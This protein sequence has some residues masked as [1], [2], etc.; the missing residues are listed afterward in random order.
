MLL[1]GDASVARN[2]D[3]HDTASSLNTLRKRGNI[4]EKEILLQIE[5]I[6][7]LL[8]NIG[9]D[10]GSVVRC[11]FVARSMVSFGTLS[12]RCFAQQL[13]LTEELASED[14]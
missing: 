4:E 1:G 11:V 3:S 9:T 12:T 2:E 5:D 13:V 7:A 8:F 14:L 10:V 6:V